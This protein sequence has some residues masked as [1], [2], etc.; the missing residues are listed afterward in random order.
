MMA[1]VDI[2]KL[3]KANIY[4]SGRPNTRDRIALINEAIRMINENPTSAMARG[5]LG[6]KNYAGFGD[7]RCDCEYGMGPTH[8]SIVFEIGRVDRSKPLGKIDLY[9]LEAVRDFSPI[10]EVG[11]YQNN[12]QKRLLTLGECLKR[13]QEAQREIEKFQAALTFQVDFQGDYT[14]DLD[15]DNSNSSE[16][17]ELK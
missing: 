16:V 15:T 4:V 7:Q 9:Y 11:T 3:L 12:Y 1:E 2:Q 17:K 6:Y 8:G 13:Y 10:E 14:A 5:Y